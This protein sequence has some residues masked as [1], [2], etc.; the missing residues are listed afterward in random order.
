MAQRDAARP[1]W[2][3]LDAAKDHRRLRDRARVASGRSVRL[4]RARAPADPRLIAADAGA[5]HRDRCLLELERIASAGAWPAEPTLRPLWERVLPSSLVLVL[6]DF[7]DDASADLALAFRGGAARSADRAAAQR[8]RTRFSVRP[9]AIGSSI[10]KAASSAAS[11]QRPCATISSIASRPRARSSRVGLPRPASATPNIS[12]THR[13]ICRCRNSSAAWAHGCAHELRAAR[14]ARPRRARGARASTRDPSRAAHRAAHDRIR[15]AALDFRAHPTASAPALRTSLAAVVAAR[16]A[17]ALALLLARP[18]LERA[19]D[20]S[21]APGSSSR[22][23]AISPRL[24]Q[25]FRRPAPTGAGW[26]RDFR[27]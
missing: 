10:A 22:P 14:T 3:K 23:A 27:R 16:A 7:F 20:R 11:K 6:S 5:R 25:P 8:R 2:R 4:D 24:A 18:V 21:I 15:G 17:R 9:A 13:P 12:S 1:E 26:R 19:A